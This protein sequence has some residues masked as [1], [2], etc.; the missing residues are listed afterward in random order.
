MT[1]DIMIDLETL[2]SG[3]A[4]NIIQIGAV[5]FDS[6]TGKTGYEF[7]AFVKDA[8]RKVDL[9]TALWWMQQ[10][11]SAQLAQNVEQRGICIGEALVLLSA[12]IGNNIGSVWALPASYDLPILKHAF[13][14]CGLAAP[15]HFRQERC[16]RTMIAESGIK[17]TPA[18]DNTHDAVFDCKVQIADLLRA[19]AALRA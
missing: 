18:G 3:D 9:S 15:W 16:A 6:E 8:S 19:R 17:R 1:T 11:L 12:R 5:V 4:A 14:Q 10:P 2:G 13:A 7:N